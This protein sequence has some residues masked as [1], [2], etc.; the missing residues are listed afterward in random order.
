MPNS[1][2]HAIIGTVGT[3]A[4]GNAC[5]TG[6]AQRVFQRTAGELFR[7]R[8]DLPR[9]LDRD[10]SS[11]RFRTGQLTLPLVALVIGTVSYEILAG[12]T[13]LD[14]LRRLIQDID[15]EIAGTHYG[16]GLRNRNMNGLKA[17]STAL[18]LLVGVAE[19]YAIFL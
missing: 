1:S 6:I 7:D 2:G 5:E 16:Q 14:D 4:G 17:V 15:E 18:F 10:S 8:P 12:N 11:D 3:P 9:Y 19:L 13:A